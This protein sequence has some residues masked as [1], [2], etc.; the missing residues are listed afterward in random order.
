MSFIWFWLPWFPLLNIIISKTY[1]L[2]HNWLHAALNCS[3]FYTFL[4]IWRR[5]YRA[6]IKPNS[7]GNIF[8]F[9]V[10]IDIF[11]FLNIHQLWNVVES[12]IKLF[13]TFSVRRR[14]QSFNI[15]LLL[16]NSSTYTSYSEQNIHVC[17]CS[18]THKLDF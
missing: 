4:I 13:S 12:W 11:L 15:Q 10:W 6:K 5:Q 9:S 2:V 14:P 18:Q 3:K 1:I 7:C 8:H 17:M 16:Y